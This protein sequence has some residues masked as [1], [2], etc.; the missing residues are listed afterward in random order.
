MIT[1]SGFKAQS[2]ILS[3]QIGLCIQWHSTDKGPKAVPVPRALWTFLALSQEY[4]K[5][6]SWFHSFPQVLTPG[7]PTGP[8]HMTL[9]W[10]MGSIP[11]SFTTLCWQWLPMWPPPH[12]SS[13]GP[14]ALLHLSFLSSWNGYL[15]R[16]Y[17]V[18]D[19]ILSTRNGG[20]RCNPY[21]MEYFVHHETGTNYTNYSAITKENSMISVLFFY[22]GMV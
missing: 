15:I 20:N 2:T 10:V 11:R 14:P 12:I 7:D 17:H 3:H 18:A 9:D 21:F 19:T 1:C 6:M 4:R 13:S 8:K 16:T 22:W 5:A